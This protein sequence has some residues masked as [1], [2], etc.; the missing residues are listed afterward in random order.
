[1]RTDYY[2][3][4][5]IIPLK[6]AGEALQPTVDEVT[7]KLEELGADIK[8]H[9]LFG[10]LK[11]AYAIEHQHQGF[12]YVVE[13]VGPREKVAELN[14]WLNLKKEVLRH[15]LIKKNPE[16]KSS[17]EVSKANAAAAKL[18]KEQ[19]AEVVEE[20]AKKPAP[21]KEEIKEK[22]ESLEKVDE[23][24]DNILEDEKKA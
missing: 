10:K 21:S 15:L 3:L 7:A 6:Y 4:M 22:K 17:L 1:M 20:E 18:A 2:E 19:G 23:K 13:F 5:Y 24:L 11:F 14:S 8:M 9:E 16:K 12:Y